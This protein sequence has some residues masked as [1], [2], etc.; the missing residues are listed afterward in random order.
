M[1]I[2]SLKVIYIDIVNLLWQQLILLLISHRRR[3]P[4]LFLHWICMYI[5]DDFFVKIN[6]ILKY[7]CTRGFGPLQFNNLIDFTNNI[8]GQNDV[9]EIYDNH[10]RCNGVLAQTCTTKKIL[11]K[12]RPSLIKCIDYSHIFLRRN[13][14]LYIG[15]EIKG[16]N[17]LLPQG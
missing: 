4:F 16:Y 9:S 5:L 10:M 17:N 11:S 13:M 15:A 1:P 2:S 3:K 14:R 7:N 6:R 12:L 8:S